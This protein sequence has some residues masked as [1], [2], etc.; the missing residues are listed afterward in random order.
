MQYA[1]ILRYDEARPQWSGEPTSWPGDNSSVVIEMEV[2]MDW[3]KIVDAYGYWAA[4]VLL[5]LLCYVF[6][7]GVVA[8]GRFPNLHTVIFG[9]VGVVC[10]VVCMYAFWCERRNDQRAAAARKERGE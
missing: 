4:Q 10:I 2:L 7:V 1:T 9:L 3:Q 8:D 6:I 5:G